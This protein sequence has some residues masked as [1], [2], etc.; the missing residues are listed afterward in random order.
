[1][2]LPSE[3]FLATRGSALA[4]AQAH[5]VQAECTAR[6]PGTRFELLVLKTTGDKLQTASMSRPEEGLPK[7]LF[8]KELE[9]ALLDGRASLAVHSLK[10]LPTALPQGLELGAVLPREDVR[11]VLVYKPAPE[12]ELPLGELPEGA[13]VATSSTR[14][15]AQLKRLRP[16]V[17]LTEIRGNVGT[18]LRKLS[19]DD[20]LTGTLLAAAG[21]RRLGFEIT[22]GGVLRG[23]DVPSGLRA[24]VL[25]TDEMIPC[26]GQAAIGLEAREGDEVARVLCEGLN[27]SDTWLAVRA[28]RAFLSAMGGGCQAPVGAHAVCDDGEGLHMR[29][30]SFMG[31]AVA[32]GE[33]SGTNMDPEGLGKALAATMKPEGEVASVNA[34]TPAGALKG[35]R[36]GK[37]YLVG[38]GPGDPGLLTLRGAEL[39]SRADVLVYDA[40]VDP[41]QL[42][43][44]PKDAEVIYAGKRSAQHAI[45]Q[46]ELNQLLVQKALEGRTV[47]RLKGGDPYLFGRGGEEAEELVAAGVPFEVV[48]GISSIVAAPNYAGIPVTH[49]DHCSGFTVITGHEDPNKEVSS[50][51]WE[52]LAK[53]PGTKIVL[54]GV[55][56]IGAITSKLIEHGM[57]PATPVAMVRWGTWARQTSI[58]GT[59]ATMADVVQ[60]AQFKAPAVTII[61]SVTS[62]RSTLNWFETRPLF[63]RRIVVTR[64]RQQASKLGDQLQ[65]LGAEVLEIP[66]IRIEP[67]TERQSL[68]EAMATLNSYSWLV[69]TSPNGVDMFFDAFFKAFDDLRDLGGVRIAAV[70]PATAAKLKAL[71]LRV[72]AMPDKYVTS[73]VTEALCAVESIENLNV[74]L[75]RAEVANPD[76]PQELEA[77]G[78]I[79][80]DVACYRTVPEMED[81]TGHAERFRNE[82]ADWITFTSSSTVENFHARF[83]LG[84]VLREF[85]SLRLASIGPETSKAIEALGLMPDVEASQHDIPGLVDAILEAESKG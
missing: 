37:V 72:D 83:D 80:D 5:Q 32:E 74:L 40:L 71:H 45:P 41:V 68:A 59:L 11:D 57:D 24:R 84:L 17:E 46:E 50:H 60:K 2:T 8:T 19:E 28:E 75:M 42:R 6:W 81:L 62:L 67:T 38:A 7:G 58:E 54:M 61:G 26:V 33:S 31:E 20:S 53:L 51:D 34:P 18:R 1:M 13:K 56:R 65:D 55:E 48:P 73:E 70:G 25:E 12:C 78:A 49:R 52:T 39:L 3:I 47:V 43:R 4:L 15:A 85:P 64:T 36:P 9:E 77:R 69:F 30:I 44:A 79:V 63:G 16:D 29:A 22:A 21:I 27:H 76:L 35:P 66:T 10:D 23:P 82:G 14:R